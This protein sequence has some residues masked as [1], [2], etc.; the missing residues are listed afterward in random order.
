MNQLVNRILFF[1]VLSLFFISCKKE[2]DPLEQALIFA[3]ENRIELEKVL[4]HYSVHQ[5]DSLKLRA[6]KFLIANMPYHYYYE[7]ELLDQY[8]NI[9]ESLMEVK[10]TDDVLN[11]FKIKYGLFSDFALNR[12]NDIQEI[13]SDYL[14]KN[15]DFAFK[16]WNE[17]P[18][19][20]SLSFH[21]FC[22][23]ILPYRV[24]VEQPTDWREILYN[25]YNPLLDDL[26]KTDAA[27]DP[28]SAAQVIIDVLCQEDKYFTATISNI[29]LKTPLILDQHRAGTCRNMA[30]L[31]VYI[32]RSLGIPC[33]VEYM[34]IHGRG[35]ASHF[36][37]FIID[38]KGET[39]TSDYLDCLILHS[40]DALHLTSK[41]YRETFSINQ[42]IRGQLLKMDKNMIAPFLR[43]PR[44]VDVTDL[45]AKIQ[46]KSISIPSMKFYSD[47]DTEIA[48][49][50]CT[51]FGSWVPVDW[52]FVKDDKV[53][54]DKI[55]PEY[56]AKSDT[57]IHGLTDEAFSLI[58]EAVSRRIEDIIY[59]VARM[60]NG[61]L[62]YITDPFILRKDDGMISFLSP[63]DKQNTICVFSKYNILVEELVQFLPGSLFEASNDIS[64][65]DVDT[66]FQ[67]EDVP[68]RLF[69]TKSFCTDKKYRYIRYRGADISHCGISEIQLFGSNS[70]RLSGVPF[71]SI[72]GKEV[73]KHGYSNAFD[74]NPYTS[75][76]SSN[77]SGDWVA[78]DLGQ[79]VTISKIIYTPRNRDNFIRVDDRYEL[80][81]L[82]RND[83]KSLG[84]QTAKADSLLFENV[85]ANA[86]LYLKN[87]TRGKDER[88]FIIEDNVQVFF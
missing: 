80:F 36:W 72:N 45:Y 58:P 11:S 15:I 79:P 34:P 76:Y 69:N 65:S 29:I 7:G 68:L 81:Y 88:V 4:D 27:L 9:Y 37:T 14:I 38:E 48:Y 43:Y 73:K 40:S 39:Y 44:F 64:F 53:I 26:R 2:I 25:K 59:R 18:W 82:D 87:H 17:Q 21:T 75:F 22:E 83:W 70:E 42:E 8:S 85:P 66:L 41:I 57:I 84:V 3:G 77:P 60:E 47:M 52:A 61:K 19:G 74:G 23:Y 71:G 13:K 1:L 51:Q 16:V 86:L 32:L 24:N 49:L 30:D 55:K 28:L 56:S 62:T 5:E 31:T 20:Q 12:K 10:D 50:C 67:I 6:A 54:F 46:T 63:E 78:L 33:G 35:N